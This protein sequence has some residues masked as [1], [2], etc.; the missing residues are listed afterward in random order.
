MIEM[1]RAPSGN[2]QSVSLVG[3]TPRKSVLT[4]RPDR[5]GGRTT[6]LPPIQGAAGVRFRYRTP[7][8]MFRAR[9]MGRGEKRRDSSLNRE[10]RI[11]IF[12]MKFLRLRFRLMKSVSLA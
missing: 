5:A 3:T 12:Q 9:P 2:V 4:C 8:S 6:Y 1:F 7:A 11:L 10:R